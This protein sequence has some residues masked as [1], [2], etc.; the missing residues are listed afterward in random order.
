MNFTPRRAAIALR[1][2]AALAFAAASM[3]VGATGLAQ[4]T[5]SSP[6]A[7][8]PNSPRKSDATWHAI[9]DCTLHV[10]PEK[11][12]EHATLVVRDGRIT[13]VVAS[14]DGKA[15]RLPLGPRVWDGAGMHVYPAFIEPYVEVDAPPPDRSLPSTHWNRNV[16]PERDALDGGGITAAQA[17][18]FRKMGFGA[19]AI[20]PRG[21][22][23]RGTA[24]VVSLGAPPGEPSGNKP[25]TYAQRVYQTIGLA[26]GG[27]FGGPSR[28][29]DTGQPAADDTAEWTGY[30]NSQMGAISLIRQTFLDSD[31]Q[32]SVRRSGS[33]AAATNS[34]DALAAIPANAGGALTPVI[35]T[36][37]AGERHAF[38]LFDV[39]NELE[40]LRAAKI[41]REFSR[42]AVLLGS[43]SEYARLEAIKKDGLPIILPLR[44]ARQPDVSTVSNAES[45]DLREL[46]A[47][48]Q[49][50]TNPR[51]LEEAGVKVCLTTAKL[52]RGQTFGDNLAKA[53]KHG[54][55]PEV[56]LAMLTTRPAELLG[57]SDRLGTLEMGKVASFVVA[58]GDLFLAEDAEKQAESKDDK[59]EGKA[60]DTKS[61]DD[62]PAAKKTRG[63]VLETWIDGVRYEIAPRKGMSLEGEW[64]MSLDP[65]PPTQAD[66]SLVIDK[67]NKVTVKRDGKTVRAAV[68]TLDVNRLNFVFDHEPLDGQKGM[69]VMS[70]T[71]ELGK[72][73]K[74]ATIVGE[75]VRPDGNRYRWTAT[76]K[77]ATLAGLWPVK[78]DADGPAPVLVFDEKNALKSVAPGSG[79]D[80]QAIAVDNATFDGKTLAY[81]VEMP[82]GKGSANVRA[83]ADFESDPPT[84]KGEV[85]GPGGTFPWTATRTSLEGTWILTEADGTA[86]DPDAAETITLVV[87][88][89]SVTVR[90]SQPDKDPIVIRTEKMKL[91]GAKLTFEHSLTPL[92]MEGTSSD[93]V[94]FD[95]ESLRGSSLLTGGKTHT[96]TAHRDSG[97]DDRRPR[98]GMRQIAQDFMKGDGS[99]DPIKDIPEHLGLPFG[100]YALD[101]YPD[102]RPTIITNATVWTSNANNDVLEHATVIL[103]GGKIVFVGAGTPPGGLPAD[104]VTIDGTCKH[105]TA[106]LIDCHSHT[107]ISRGVNESGQAVTAEVRI[108]DVTDPNSISWYRQLA[109]GVTAVNNLHGSA[110]PIGGQ[111]CVNKVRWGALNPDDMHFDGSDAYSDA[112]DVGVEQRASHTMNGIKFALGENVKGSNW[113]ERATSRYP[114]TRMGV[115]ALI[116]DRFVAAREYAAAWKEY[117]RKHRIATAG[118]P[119]T[120][121]ESAADASGPAPRRDLELE[122]LAQVLE[123]KR[124]VHCHSYR[125]DEILMLAR[126][127]KEFNFKIG[128]FQHV[129]EGYKVADAIRDSAI[130]A[131]GFTDWWNYKVEVQD[132]IPQGFPIMHEVGVVVSF[133]SD[134]DELARRLNTEAAKAV[135]YGNVPP[136]EA[137]RF[138]TINPAKQLMIDDRVGS[139]EI[140]KDADVAVWS[141]DPMSS[142]TRCERTF[143][144]GR[145]LFSL[146]QDAAHRAKIKAER[147]RIIQKILAEKQ[148]PGGGRGEAGPR[149]GPDAGPG[150]GRP[151]GGRR[152]PEDTSGTYDPGAGF[153]SED[154]A[155]AAQREYYLDLIRRGISPDFALPGQCGCGQMH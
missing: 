116:R 27:G 26:G 94:I 101:S 125:S 153:A 149:G 63:K 39:D 115:E 32:T 72:D 104:A 16:M 68:S 154:E 87:A 120:T 93:T 76:K 143:V 69:F 150:G 36:A 17:E 70:G 12:V 112:N 75:G 6:L 95:G 124:L 28:N 123:G 141:G 21:G 111:N 59:T 71:M 133:N 148:T 11:V 138:V 88:K 52:T 58:D 25:P 103:A 82:D 90:V 102:A 43:G 54:L 107:G 122:A 89:D 139:L 35:M 86:R 23:F 118:N 19:A 7:P 1:S 66:R 73:G 60:G 74:P 2:A 47:W 46:M 77:P 10:S 65:A 67:D 121:P 109:G 127:A 55:K 140:G 42:P 136:A 33:L 49:S 13:G 144:D 61:A 56:A 62:K 145:E 40:A 106:G 51:R 105:V 80:S 57:V 91:D 130:G 126:L 30:P 20:S 38:Y 9:T 114:Q 117:E 18:S 119:A 29:T 4:P 45:V 34:L 53:I 100:P 146:E 110:N 96:Y 41:A 142:Y 44:Y 135:K 137:L 134:S 84:L 24:A 81:S 113:S 108:Q 131:S 64:A 83:Q 99:K 50:P 128:T 129:L 22:I 132:A 15:A 97:K 78:F 147:Q 152:R 98:G 79:P 48:E 37:P 3:F 5:S 31:W 92:G 14:Q 151:G 8:P 155:I 85:K